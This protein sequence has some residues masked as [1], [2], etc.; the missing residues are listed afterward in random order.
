[1]KIATYNVASGGYS[2]YDSTA[3]LPER[4]QLL[5]SRIRATDADILGLTD[6]FRWQETFSSQQVQRLFN[7]PYSYHIDMDDARVD[8]RIGVALLSRYPIVDYKEVRLHSRSAIK[9]TIRLEDHDELLEI[10]IVYLDDLSEL[11]R[12]EQTDSLISY[13]PTYKPTIIM[14]DF[15]AIW[16]QHAPMLK[17][18]ADNFFASV[19]D[20]DNDIDY[21]AVR[22]TVASLYKATTLPSLAAH[23]FSEP[24]DLFPTAL[25]PLHDLKL[26]TIFPVDHIL[27]RGCTLTNYSV[28][29]GRE[30]EAA[31][32]HFPLTA[33][34]HFAKTKS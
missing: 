9:A 18:A 33:E 19:S 13:L 22:K 21:S 32:D 28:L 5:Q 10:F 23:G 12:Q 24:L 26:P 29:T 7:Y 11:T 8:T 17:K 20:V 3:K 27:G 16:P 14:G 25:T 15:N 1:V 31:S 30:F 4:L 2:S 6:T 34:C